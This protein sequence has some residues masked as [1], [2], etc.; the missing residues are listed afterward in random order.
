MQTG[1]GTMHVSLLLVSFQLTR[2][3]AFFV[4]KPC[5]LSRTSVE[6]TLLK[7]SV[8]PTSQRNVTTEEKLGFFFKPI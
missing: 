7:S 3:A 2:E 5:F 1:G 8:M 6:I 4:Y